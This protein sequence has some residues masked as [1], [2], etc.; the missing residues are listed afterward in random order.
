[1]RRELW[2]NF[3]LPEALREKTR[4]SLRQFVTEQAE[5]D[6]QSAVIAWD[7]YGLIDGDLVHRHGIAPY[8][9]YELNV[10][11]ADGIT[12]IAVL[13]SNQV[14]D[15][16][17]SFDKS[18]Y[19]DALKVIGLEGFLSTPLDRSLFVSR[20]DGKGPPV[21]FWQEMVN[22]KKWETDTLVGLLFSMLLYFE[23]N[24]KNQFEGVCSGSAR[25]MLGNE[26]LR[27]LDIF[28]KI[29]TVINKGT[30]FA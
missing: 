5:I 15:H 23:L 16:F 22:G 3:S 17:R 27:S 28:E 12:L 20:K 2:P 25:Q 19:D 13:A 8:Y 18:K 14:A 11:G 24:K 6:A 29:E 4:A 30:L 7:W 1:M 21:S 26:E 9:N 10:F